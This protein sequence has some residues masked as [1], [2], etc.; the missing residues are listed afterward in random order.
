[1]RQRVHTWLVNTRKVL[2]FLPE[3][4]EIGILLPLPL[5]RFVFIYILET[6]KWGYSVGYYVLAANLLLVRYIIYAFVYG[7][8]ILVDYLGEMNSKDL[9][10]LYLAGVILLGIGIAFLVNY[11]VGKKMLAKEMEAEQNKLLEQS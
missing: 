4:T 2:Q 11:H 9:R 10:M 1:M 7:K 5:L 3:V 8:K 6:V